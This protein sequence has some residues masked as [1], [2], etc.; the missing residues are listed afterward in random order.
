MTCLKLANLIRFYTKTNTNTFSDADMLMLANVY[1][2]DI[3]ESIT[4]ANEDFFIQPATTDLALGQREYTFP[5]DMILKMKYLEVKFSTDGQWIKA[6]EID[7]GDLDNRPT[8]EANIISMFGNEVGRLRFDLFRGSMYLY[9]GTIANSVVDGI[10]LWYASKPAP[11]PNMTNDVV[12]I[13]TAPSNIEH[14]FPEPF[15][16]LLAR[17]VSMFFKDSADRPIP[18]NQQEQ[19]Y[20]LDLAAKIAKIKNPNLDRAIQRSVP[21]M[22]NFG[23]N[24]YD[25]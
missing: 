21:T 1:M 22:A 8:D 6:T 7:L 24:G 19:I 14:G 12:D 17:R 20:Q 13:S 2:L 4:E 23:N 10:K 15:H 5:A 16:E 18:Y 11:L 25:Y 9:S 3:A